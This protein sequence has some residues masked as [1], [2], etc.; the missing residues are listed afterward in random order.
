MISQVK[1]ESHM[2]TLLAMQHSAA[3]SAAGCVTQASRQ[4]P[5]SHAHTNT[6]AHRNRYKLQTVTD[7]HLNR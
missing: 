7:Q 5:L 4:P 2:H 1:G 3:L 6:D